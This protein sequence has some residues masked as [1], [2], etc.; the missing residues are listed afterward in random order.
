MNYLAA[1]VNLV[2]VL[3]GAVLLSLEYGWKVGVG[4]ALLVYFH[5]AER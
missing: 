2:G 4:V 3:G 5:K 1:G